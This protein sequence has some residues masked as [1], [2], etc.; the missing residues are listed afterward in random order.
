VTLNRSKNDVY[1]K[2][3]KIFVVLIIGKDNKMGDDT[4]D[5]MSE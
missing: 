3:T 5:K 4:P 2:T 1:R